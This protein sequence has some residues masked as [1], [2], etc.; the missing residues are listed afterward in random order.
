MTTY[1][2]CKNIEMERM[3][4]QKIVTM[5]YPF[6]EANDGGILARDLDGCHS[7]IYSYVHIYF[8]FQVA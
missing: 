7:F 2:S 1:S 6:Y 4:I 3:S 5:L 8:L